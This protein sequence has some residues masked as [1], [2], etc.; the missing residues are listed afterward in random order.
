MSF[1]RDT[2]RILP[3]SHSPALLERENSIDPVFPPSAYEPFQIRL[4]LGH[5]LRCLVEIIILKN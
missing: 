3:S 4:E 1:I 5:L 2:I